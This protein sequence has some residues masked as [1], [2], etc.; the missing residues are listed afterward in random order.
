[1]TSAAVRLVP[2]SVRKNR[3]LAGLLGLGLLMLA[4]VA[5]GPRIFQAYGFTGFVP[6]IIASSVIT[7]AAA[8]LAP[9]VSPRAGLIII[10]GLAVVMRVGIMNG[11]PFLSTDL[12]RYIWD[13][14]VQAA[15]INPYLYVP[16]NPALA[17]LRDAAIYPNINRAD[18]AVTA[19]PP[20]AQ[21]FFLA[22]TRVSESL[23][24]MRLAMVS[25]EIIVVAV[26]ID[27]L[28]RLQRPV[29]AVVAW[30]WHPLA[31][32]EIANSAHVEVL[33]V[34]LM[35]AGVWLMARS[36]ALWGAVVVG[37]AALVKPYAVV[38]LPAFWRFWDWPTPLAVI[39]FAGLC[40]VP[41]LGAG[42][43]VLGYLGTGYLAEEGFV[44][45]D[46]FW[47]VGLARAALGD[48]PGL[49][50]TYLLLAAGGMSWLALR[51]VARADAPLPTKLQDTAGL[52]MTALF[53]MSPHYPWYFLA[54]VP[55]IA[56]VGGGPLWT[57]SIAATLLYRPPV[58]TDSELVWRC[59]AG[60]PFVVAITIA[61]VRQQGSSTKA[62]GASLWTG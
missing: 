38:A 13:G 52:L 12:Y 9:H 24:L 36:K 44:S 21:M 3:P 49:R 29:T 23:A 45:G 51:S 56:L 32:W 41:Y 60:L 17:P 30:A 33:M 19:Y 54:I 16:A 25:C 7:V 1:M 26:L 55:F 2:R 58:L 4:V 35:M 22:V 28:R 37:L 46:G 18:Y 27:L 50:T 42:S 5:S 14:R 53:F 8:R 39:M 57:M 15:G 59:L 10:L 61:W 43:G 6:W 62:Q 20:V 31:I 48:I 34:A 47:Q 40:Y 11:A